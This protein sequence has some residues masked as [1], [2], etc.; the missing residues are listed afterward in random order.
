M[1]ANKNFAK[2]L[3]CG[4]QISGTFGLHHVQPIK[5]PT[6]YEF[7][8]REWS[9]AAVPPSTHC[10][11]LTAIGVGFLKPLSVYFNQAVDKWM[12]QHPVRKITQFQISELLGKSYGRAASVAKAVTGFARTGVWP[13]DPNVFQHSDFA[14]STQESYP[15]AGT[16]NL[17]TE[18]QAST[19]SNPRQENKFPNQS[20][21]LL[22]GRLKKYHLCLKAME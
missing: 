16:T 9:D 11:S 6:S 14:A 5:K 2:W 22:T 7:G 3:S 15:L 18:C 10:T 1:E 13:V 12:R 20:R 21:Q 8:K 19:S 17:V 4:I